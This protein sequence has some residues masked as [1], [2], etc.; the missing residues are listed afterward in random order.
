MSLMLVID[1]YLFLPNPIIGIYDKDSSKIIKADLK[2]I[3]DFCRKQKTK[4]VFD[5]ETWKNIDLNFIRKLSMTSRD[6]ELD[7]ALTIFRND[8]LNVI[9][10]NESEKTRTWGLNSLFYGIANE[11]NKTFADAVAKSILHCIKN[12]FPVSIFVKE[13]LGRN[14]KEIRAG[15]S[16]II[17]R[18]RWRIYISQKGFSNPYPIPCITCERNFTTDWSARHDVNLPSSGKYEFIPRS[19]W[20]LK[21]TSVSGV[22]DSKPVFFDRLGNGWAR[23]NTP[24]SP[25]HWDVYIKDPGWKAVFKVDQINISRN[26][27]PKEQGI[28]GTI[29]HIPKNKASIIKS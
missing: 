9:D 14:I 6:S 21:K 28:E 2:K 22:M 20:D 16:F 24:G 26:G 8:L 25:Y 5:R 15:H 4:V 7:V 11:T 3:I 27:I 13:I 12:N 18:T 10:F 17:E 29:H 1:P 19:R 23:P